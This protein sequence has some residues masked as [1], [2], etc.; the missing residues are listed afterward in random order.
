MT[1]QPKLTTVST[2]PARQ[3]HTT[4]TLLTV[5]QDSHPLKQSRKYYGIPFKGMPGLRSPLL[6]R[7]DTLIHFL[8]LTVSKMTHNL[9]RAFLNVKNWELWIS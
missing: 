9:T 2:R 1:H 7:Y 5:F 3:Q 4:S 6:T 8:C